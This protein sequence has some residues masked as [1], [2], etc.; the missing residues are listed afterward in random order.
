MIPSVTLPEAVFE[1]SENISDEVRCFYAPI[2]QGHQAHVCLP[3][4]YT[5]SE[6][7]FTLT[8]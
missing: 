5:A 2:P 3:P 7:L 1:T 8:F 4:N 6:L